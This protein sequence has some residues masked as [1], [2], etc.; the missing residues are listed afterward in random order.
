MVGAIS[1]NLRRVTLQVPR[2]G[3][4]CLRFVIE[5]DVP[6]DREEIEDIAFE[7][8]ALQTQGIDLEVLVTVDD[9]PSSELR[10]PGRLVFARKE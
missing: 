10:I 6:A 9:R 3:A 7:F 1:S 5:R 2:P 8:E 4:V